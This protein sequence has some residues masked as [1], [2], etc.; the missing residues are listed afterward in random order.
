ML[1]LALIAR[2]PKAGIASFN[3]YENQVLPLLTDHG[4]VLQ[5]RLR[6][7]DGTVE[8]HLVGFPSEAAFD[9]FR[10]DPRRA[11]YAPLMADSGAVAEL[12][13]VCDVL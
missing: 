6:T 8:I 13:R 7:G 4:G 1:T 3:A 11:A 12:L 2:I 9:A 10:Q 5:R